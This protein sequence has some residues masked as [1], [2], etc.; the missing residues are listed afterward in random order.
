M[1]LLRAAFESTVDSL[2]IA[3]GH[4]RT[5]AACRLWDLANG[6]SAKRSPKSG[7]F[8]APVVSTRKKYISALMFPHN[9]LTVLPYNRCVKSLNG[10]SA[11]SFLQEVSSRFLV[12]PCSRDADSLTSGVSQSTDGESQQSSLSGQSDSDVETE[13]VEEEEMDI[14]MY[15]DGR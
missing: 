8:T 14:R 13:G 15:M 7:R 10:H 12:T 11:D 1:N 3:D 4:H 9:Q 2:Y 6:D 5:A